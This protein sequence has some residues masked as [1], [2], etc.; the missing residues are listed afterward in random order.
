MDSNGCFDKFASF[1]TISF[2]GCVSA[3][4]CTHAN[5]GLWLSLERVSAEV[6]DASGKG[7][8]AL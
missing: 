7:F 6:G 2:P 5:S 1:S 8:S 4:S 3:Q